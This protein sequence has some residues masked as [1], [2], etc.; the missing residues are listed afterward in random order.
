MA[1]AIIA[2]TLQVWWSALFWRWSMSWWRSLFLLT[3]QKVI[4]IIWWLKND[5]NVIE[6]RMIKVAMILMSCWYWL[7]SSH[8][9]NGQITK[10]LKIIILRQIRTWL[11]ETCSISWWEDS[12][13]FKGIKLGRG[14]KSELNQI[15]LK[16]ILRWG[17]VDMETYKP[18][19]GRWMQSEG[20]LQDDSVKIMLMVV[21]FCI[22]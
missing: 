21:M 7:S 3:L 17:Q 2:L 1:A 11:G 8:L 22:L 6:L 13:I 18:R 14:M 9:Y 12:T 16:L 4:S 15:C 10:T 19:I 5:Q 20:A